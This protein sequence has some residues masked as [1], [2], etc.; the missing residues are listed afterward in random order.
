MD[1][2]IYKVAPVLLG[3][4]MDAVLGDPYSLPHPVRLFGRLISFFERHWNQGSY[5]KLKGV[6][7]TLLLV[8][9]V[10]LF[11]TALLYFIKDMVYIRILITSVFFF[12]GISSRSLL[13][14]AWKVERKLILNDLEGAREQLSWIVGR[15]TANLSPGQIRMATLETLSE[16]LSDGVVAP[17][18]YYALGGIP[19]MMAYKMINTLDSMVGY[20]NERF[21][22][23][24]YSSAKLD[25]IANFIP[26]RLT[27]IFMVIVSGSIRSFKFIRLY[28]SKHASPNSGYPESALAGILD[29]RMGGPNVYHGQIV[30]K[31]YIGDNPREVSH[32]DFLKACNVNIKVMI[33]SV[34][35]LLLQALF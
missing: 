34:F 1:N 30:E 8:S 6:L 20:K 28:G 3:S 23:F 4:I 35:I 14:E 10:W 13:N 15:D 12:Y 24:G 5:R 25:D 31:P 22:L 27:A 29:C 26:A 17:L 2:E 11:F 32:K 7:M 16:N 19:A 33:L 21:H 9:S 18:F